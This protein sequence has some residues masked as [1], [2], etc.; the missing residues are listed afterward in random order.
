MFSPHSLLE[1]TVKKYDHGFSDSEV[2]RIKREFELLKENGG[3]K[4]LQDFKRIVV[5][6]IIVTRTE[7]FIL[8]EDKQKK[9]KANSED[10]PK[11]S[12]SN[13]NNKPKKLTKKQIQER[14][15]EIIHKMLTGIALS[16]EENS[17]YQEQISKI[18]QELG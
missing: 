9:S 3:P 2:I 10:K 4:S 8:Q 11:K 13:S 5:P 1:S 17:L 7:E 18:S 16:E 12:K 15:N 6:H 14:M